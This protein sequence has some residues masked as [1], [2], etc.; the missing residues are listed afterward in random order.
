MTS[1]EAA[2]ADTLA[3]LLNDVA[4][5]IFTGWNAYYKGQQGR[6]IP[7]L[8][9]RIQRAKYLLEDVKMWPPSLKNAEAL[10][11]QPS[12][13]LDGKEIAT[14]M[15]IILFYRTNAKP[16]PE[17]IADIF[18]LTTKIGSMQGEIEV[19]DSTKAS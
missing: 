15:G 3:K 19:L 16:T 9:H 13:R 12:A 7:T 2:G 10:E 17:Q 14:L 8:L 11:A 5:E 18:R 6:D 1:P 4:Y